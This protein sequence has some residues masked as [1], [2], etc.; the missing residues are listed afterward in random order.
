MSRYPT[1]SP[2]FKTQT[3]LSFR[4]PLIH[5]FRMSLNT[6]WTP[7]Q[8]PLSSYP[9][10]LSQAFTSRTPT[11]LERSIAYD[12]AHPTPFVPPPEFASL[13]REARL[14]VGD[15]T[16]DIKMEDF[17]NTLNKAGRAARALVRFPDLHIYPESSPDPI[18][19]SPFGLISRLS[20]LLTR[21][22][23][24]TLVSMSNSRLFDSNTRLLMKRRT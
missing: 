12:M 8:S 15:F 22:T 24:C 1:L 6:H 4:I 10:L 11:A 20:P 23:H 21:Y 18:P 3:V 9:R 7:Y 14:G 5:N 16:D 2:I 19:R 13:Y 17:E